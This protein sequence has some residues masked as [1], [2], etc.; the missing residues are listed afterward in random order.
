M[1]FLWNYMQTMANNTKCFIL[2]D[3]DS[4]MAP[5]IMAL[6]ANLPHKPVNGTII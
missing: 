3:Q 2:F 5:F 6:S 1:V 4:V